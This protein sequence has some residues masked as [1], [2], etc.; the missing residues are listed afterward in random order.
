MQRRIARVRRG[1][2]PAAYRGGSL[3]RLLG[4]CGVIACGRGALRWEFRVITR[5][6]V[7]YV[8]GYDPQGPQGYYGLFG[9]LLKRASELWQVKP[10]LGALASESSD[11]ACWRVTTSGP[12][13]RVVT[14]YDFVRYEDIIL[15]NMAQPIVRQLLRALHWMID[16]L[17]TGTTV[18]TFR[19]RWSFGMHQLVLQA[20]MVAWI[21]V[22][23]V[24]G[25]L[26]WC[27]AR[28]LLG[29]HALVLLVI[30]AMAAIA[31]FIA[32]RPLAERWFVIRVN[33]H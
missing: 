23:V 28:S 13:W 6:R 27:T 26:V 16:D 21:A 32:L 9:H 7:V 22:P 33:N 15:A 17:V 2:D 30:A 18:R 3:R 1:A 29:W 20:L 5:R 12:N 4:Q 19:A 10:D 25:A 24:A 11:I 31:V 14:N 8:H